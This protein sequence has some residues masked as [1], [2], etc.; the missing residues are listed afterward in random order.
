MAGLDNLLAKAIDVTI[1]TNLSERVLQKIETRLFEKYGITISE[2][3]EEFQKFDSILRE[4]FG[5]GADG[6]EKKI[7]KNIFTLEQTRDRDYEWIAIEDKILTKI[8]LEA[9][10]DEEKKKILMASID[11]PR[12][13][14]EIFSV[15]TVTQTSGY[16][17]INSL[18]DNGLLVPCGYI[19]SSYGRK[20]NKYISIFQNV[21]IEIVR[22]KIVVKVKVSREYLNKSSV[23]PLIQ[24]L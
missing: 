20:I 5:A 1:R 7:L 12:V 13:I 17:K 11:E 2:A 14:S 24:S 18:I 23:V 21:K 8:I 3:L 10:G 4:F 19:S 16:R 15:C 22:E 6:L 9:F